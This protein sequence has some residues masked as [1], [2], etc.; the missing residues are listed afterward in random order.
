MCLYWNLPSLPWKHVALISECLLWGR[1]ETSH[2]LAVVIQ[3]QPL[4]FTSGTS[5]VQL[6]SCLMALQNHLGSQGA[7]LLNLVIHNHHH[8]ILPK[9]RLLLILLL[10]IS[11]NAHPNPGPEQNMSYVI[12]FC[13]LNVRSLVGKID[14]VRIWAL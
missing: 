11:G 7:A 13:H 14:M 3:P 2:Q 9:Q 1:S 12:G 6:L 10:L 4:L 8:C 5:E